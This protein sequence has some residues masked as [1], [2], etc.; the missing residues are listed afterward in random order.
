MVILLWSVFV[1]AEIVPARSVLSSGPLYLDKL[2]CD[3]ESDNSLQDC[4]SLIPAFGLTTCDHLSDTWIRCSGYCEVD[5]VFISN[6]SVLF[7]T[8]R[9]QR[10]F[11]E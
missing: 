1:A 7:I 5:D 6:L 2:L 11:G 10:V 8:F 3:E 9:Y 4:N